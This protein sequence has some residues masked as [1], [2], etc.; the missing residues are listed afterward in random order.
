MYFDR[1]GNFVRT[2]MWAEGQWLDLWSVP[3]FLSGIALAFTIY[4]FHFEIAPSFVIGFILLVLYELFEVVAKIEETPTNRIMDVVVGMTSFTPTF[5]LAPRVSP[6]QLIFI[7]GI[8]LTIDIILSTLGWSAS[9]K[10]AV[11]EQNL[12][13]ELEEQKQKFRARRLRRKDKKLQKRLART[14][15]FWMRKK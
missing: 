8:I 7:F 11:L 13:R 2:D 1:H 15:R 3:H 6:S 5:L 12:R 4:F 14:K 10:A 9:K